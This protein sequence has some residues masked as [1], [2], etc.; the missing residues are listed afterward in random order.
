MKIA[1]LF[2]AHEI[3][4]LLRAIDRVLYLGAGNA[5]LGTVDEVIT[6]PVLSKLYNADIEVVRIKDRVFV[7]AGDIE[8]EREAHRH[9]HGHG[10][11]HSHGDAHV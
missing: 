6:G 4:P 5:V 7:M 8:V 11:D 10:H 3:N 1:I 9:E 2:S